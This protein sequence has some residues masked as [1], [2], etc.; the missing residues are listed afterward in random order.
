M[1]RTTHEDE[2]EDD[3]WEPDDHEWEPDDADLATINCPACGREMIE[4]SIRCPHCGEYR[5]EESQPTETKPNWI[6]FGL[7]LA[8][9]AAALWLMGN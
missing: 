6:I 4:E 5:S 3:E 9:I 1:P 7:I 8:F 2:W